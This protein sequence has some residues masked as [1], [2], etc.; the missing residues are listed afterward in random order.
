MEEW[1]SGICKGSTGE[2]T[3]KLMNAFVGDFWGHLYGKFTE[4]IGLTAPGNY[5]A[6]IW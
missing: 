1:H 5:S 2:K 6:S 3:A 4:K